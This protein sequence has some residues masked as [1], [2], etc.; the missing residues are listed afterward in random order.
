MSSRCLAVFLSQAATGG[1]FIQP[2]S[3]WQNG[4][5]ESFISRLWAEPLDVEVLYNL[6]DAQMKLAVYRR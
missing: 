6:A 3:P 1:R 2:G 5:A 4:H